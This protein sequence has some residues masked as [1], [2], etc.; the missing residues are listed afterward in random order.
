M[1]T[2][3]FQAEHLQA[4]GKSH[5]I[6]IEYGAGMRDQVYL[7]LPEP[8]WRTPRALYAAAACLALLIVLALLFWRLRS[9]KAAAPMSEAVADVRPAPSAPPAPP[10]LRAATVAEPSPRVMR[11][12]QT[13]APVISY[14][15]ST[16]QANTEVKPVRGPT[17]L[18]PNPTSAAVSL[19]LNAVSGPYAGQTFP[20]TEQE[21]WIGSAANNHLCLS[22]DEGVSGNHV[23][24]R[25]EQPFYRLYDNG[26]LNNTWVN[27]RPIGQEIT[28]IQPG[29]LMRVGASEFSIEANV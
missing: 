10:P 16:P 13:A 14:T 26:S 28:L 8:F 1:P 5:Q 24:I 25:R 11:P 29:D 9:P 7:K 27:G 22:A 23:C 4:D 6:G 17:A 18:A 20:V 12:I 15:S 3:E 19:S 21:F 2:L